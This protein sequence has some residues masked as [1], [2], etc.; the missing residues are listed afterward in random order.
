[1][2]R[3]PAA[4]RF[5]RNC[6]LAS[7][8]GQIVAAHELGL[9]LAAILVGKTAF[10]VGLVARDIRLARPKADRNAAI[11][12]AAGTLAFALAAGLPIEDVR[13]G[14]EGE[15]LAVAGAAAVLLMPWIEDGRFVRLVR[16]LDVYRFDG[17]REVSWSTASTS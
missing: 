14:L 1:M 17:K 10:D 5:D 9:E 7:T 11:I 6:V 13:A 4:K 15:A 2:I 3:L 16:A 8:A 12:T